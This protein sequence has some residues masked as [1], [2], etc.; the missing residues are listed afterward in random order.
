MFSSIR[1]LV[2][3]GVLAA[4]AVAPC[5]AAGAETGVIFVVEGVGGFDVLGAVS[6]K[7]LPRAGVPHEIRVFIWTHGWGQLFRDLQDFRYLQKRADEL[8]DH[9]RVYRETHPGQPI[10]LVGRSGGAGLALLAA[11]QLPPGTLER[12]ILLSPAVTPDY[13]LRPALRATRCEIVSFNSAHDRFIL[14]W[15]T[16]RFGT[17]DRVYGPSAGLRGFRVPDGLSAA[18]QELYARLVQIAWHPAMILEGHLG[19]HLGTTMPG[20]LSKE[21]APWLK[22]EGDGR[23]AGQYKPNRVTSRR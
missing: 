20:F 22:P 7:T 12:I 4:L 18:D 15:G 13:D 8:A 9:V 21:V 19:A 10:Y 5:A 1:R 17:V 23:S 2:S 16:G 6:E 11:E 3:A 14:E